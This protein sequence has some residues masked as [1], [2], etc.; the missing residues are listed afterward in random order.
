MHLG[1]ERGKSELFPHEKEWETVAEQTIR[2]LWKVIPEARDIQHVG[3]TAIESID[4]KPIVDIAVAL[5]DVHSVIPH[6][7]ELAGYGIFYR[8]SDVPEQILFIIG[9]GNIRTHHIH[10]V[11]WH[12]KAWDNYIIFRDYLNS[13]PDRASEYEK[14]KKHLASSFPDNRRA[15]TEGK[16]GFIEKIIAEAREC[17]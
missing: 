7:D 9:E 15:Y 6:I 16:A 3:S 8:G 10:I 1:L 2:T 12:G 4:A 11:K 17:F 13:H 5:D 14:L